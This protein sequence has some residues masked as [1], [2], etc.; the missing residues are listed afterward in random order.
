[1]DDLGK[2]DDVMIDFLKSQ[3]NTEKDI[4][5]F[6]ESVYG[7]QY[8][9]ELF[10]GEEEFFKKNT[11]VG[12]MAADD[13]RIVINPYSSLSPDQKRAVMLNEAA[14]IYM[15][16]G[17]IAPPQFQLTQEQLKSLGDYSKDLNDIRQTI[18][19]RI[20][21]GDSSAG[22]PTPEQMVYVEMLEKL[23]GIKPNGF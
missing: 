15:R 5:T 8:R 2:N 21:S 10:P 12:G 4:N 22:T 1:V 18:V 13:D 16:Q 11:H 6:P 9:Q 3:K 19:G 23:M 17:K 7:I 14:R 20:I